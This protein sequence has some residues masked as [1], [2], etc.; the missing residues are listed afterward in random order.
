MEFP[1][2]PD[3]FSD[4]HCDR[5]CNAW[6]DPFILSLGWLSGLVDLNIFGFKKINMNL[7]IK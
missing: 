4:F 5:A 1:A 7:I 2:V 6:T 3:F